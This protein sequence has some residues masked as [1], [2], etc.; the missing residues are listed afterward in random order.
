MKNNIN[1]QSTESLREEEARLAKKKIRTALYTIL[2]SPTVFGKMF[3]MN[4]LMNN[5]KLKNATW[6]YKDYPYANWKLDYDR[7]D[8]LMKMHPKNHKYSE[9]FLDK[10]VL[11]NLIDI[12]LITDANSDAQAALMDFADE[13][14]E[15]IDF[16]DQESIDNL[17]ERVDL[18]WEYKWQIISNHK[19]NSDALVMQYCFFWLQ[20]YWYIPP[21]FKLRFIRWLHMASSPDV[22]AFSVWFNALDIFGPKDYRHIYK[23]LLGKQ[24]EQDEELE[25]LKKYFP[26][27]YE[28]HFDMREYIDAQDIFATFE[29]IKSEQM[30]ARPDNEVNLFYPSAGR[31]PGSWVVESDALQPWVKPMLTLSSCVYLPVVFGWLT[32]FMKI[33]VPSLWELIGLQKKWMYFKK[34][35]IKIRIWKPFIGGELSAQ[36]ANQRLVDINFSLSQKI[37]S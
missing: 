16:Y 6:V 30:I 20:K 23:K 24:R 1:K 12:K 32:Q 3:N 26:L 36:E 27:S 17:F 28:K 14:I 8:K 10:Y 5:N 4:F 35:K 11:D 7:I 2:N 25:E 21:E 9:L 18:L 33:W 31:I 29:K 22:R 13:V 19:T 15:S 37:D 34:W